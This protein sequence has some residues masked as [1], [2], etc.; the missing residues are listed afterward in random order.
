MEHLLEKI[1]TF[2]VELK[3][4]LANLNSMQTKLQEEVNLMKIDMKENMNSIHVKLKV[5]EEQAD[6]VEE[7]AIQYRN[8]F[9]QQNKS[10]R[11]EIE[12][13]K[14]NIQEIRHNTELV[15]CDNESTAVKHMEFMKQ[16]KREV[17][18][19]VSRL[20][21]KSKLTTFEIR[22]DISILRNDFQKDIKDIEETLLYNSK[23][24]KPKARW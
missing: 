13:I 9:E 11:N 21:D 22:N 1:E 8:T 7:N 3:T 10:T 19:D 4:E 14:G 24:K 18:T 12:N 6:T 17:D 15:K 2:S 16:L 23:G 5:I 20:E